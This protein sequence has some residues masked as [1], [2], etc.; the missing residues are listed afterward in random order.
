LILA[1]GIAGAALFRR[2][3]PYAAGLTAGE[4]GFAFSSSA[5]GGSSACRPHCTRSETVTRRPV[6]EQRLAWEPEKG[7]TGGPFQKCSGSDL[8]SHTVPR[9][10]PSALEGLTSVFGMETGEHLRYGHRERL[11]SVFKLR[12]LPRTFK[13]AQRS[14]RFKTKPS[15]Y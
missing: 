6:P 7:R 10:V 8:L 13:T 2:G 1:S 4:R 12:T 5:D 11:Y 15:T 14:P 9:A 3:R